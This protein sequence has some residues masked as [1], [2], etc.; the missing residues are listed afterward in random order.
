VREHF[1]LL[2]Y[3]FSG[4][5]DTVIFL[6]EMAGILLLELLHQTF[7]ML[8]ILETGSRKLFAQAGLKPRSS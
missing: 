5:N 4:G 2:I 7:F 3:N 8:G 1:L 6:G